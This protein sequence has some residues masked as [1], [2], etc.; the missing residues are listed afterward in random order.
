MP[1]PAAVTSATFTSPLPG[2]LS[3][4]PVGYILLASRPLSPTEDTDPPVTKVY[5]VDQDSLVATCRSATVACPERSERYVSEA[6]YMESRLI[7]SSAARYAG[8]G[9]P[10]LRA[11]ALA[12]TVPHRTAPLRA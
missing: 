12:P 4:R 3:L 9:Q 1:L 11:L 6:R 10:Q 7:R 2:F 5:T 8:T